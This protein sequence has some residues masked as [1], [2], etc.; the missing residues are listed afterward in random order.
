M[1]GIELYLY[2][3]LPSLSANYKN[4]GTTKK[5]RFPPEFSF[6]TKY[7]KMSY[8]FATA[9]KAFANLDFLLATV[10]LCS[11][12]L[13]AALSR[14]LV[15]VLYASAAPLPLAI[16]SL[17]FLT[18]VLRADFLIVF[19]KVFVSVTFTLFIADLIFGKLF[20]SC[21]SKFA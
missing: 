19:F 7:S 21:D 16:A 11:K 12:F 14:A 20:T 4:C 2:K 3:Y 10:F 18:V 6:F 13:A 1:A 9:F 8:Y 15:V 5:L 17:H